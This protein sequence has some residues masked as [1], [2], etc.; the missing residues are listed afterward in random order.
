MK[1]MRTHGDTAAFLLLR[2]QGQDQPVVLVLGGFQ[3]PL[4]FGQGPAGLVLSP[5]AFGFQRSRVHR[6]AVQLRVL[7]DEQHVQPRQFRLEFGYLQL[8]QEFSTSS[9][10]GAIED[11]TRKSMSFC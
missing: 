7:F 4:Q 1:T 2:G 5:L 10:I 8:R 6:L 9:H 11:L 3:P